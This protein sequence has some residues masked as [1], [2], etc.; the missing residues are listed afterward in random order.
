MGHFN[1]AG[2]TEVEDFW[3]VN[4]HRLLI[5]A[6]EKSGLLEKPRPT[7]ELYGMDADGS[8]QGILI[9]YRAVTQESG[10]H[11]TVG[12][13]TQAGA[14]TMVAH[15]PGD[16]DHVIVAVWPYGSGASG[17][18]KAA[19]MDV[20]TGQTVVVATAPVRNADFTTDLQGNV[21]FATG[22]DN[23][24][25]L[26]TYYRDDAN[27]SWVLLNDAAV[28]K[29]NL[30]PLG[31]GADGRTA[32]LTREDAG[33]GP[34]TLVAYDTTSHT[35]KDVRRDATADPEPVYGAHR[36]LIGVRYVDAKP[37]FVFFNEQGDIEQSFRALEGSFADQAVAP[38]GFTT[39][40]K[41]MLVFVYSDRSPGDYYLFDLGSKKAVHLASHRDWIDPDRMGPQRAVTL[42][43]RDGVVLHGFLT[44]PAGSTGKNLPLVVNPHG[45]PFF[46]ADRW[47]FDGEVQLLASRGYAVLQLNYRGSSGFG[48]QF[49]HS[50]YLQWGR[51]MQDDLTDATKWAIAQGI[52]DPKRI[53]IYGASYGGYAALEGVAK[54]P[55]LYRCAAGYVGVYD[56]PT[57]YHAG[58]V[59]ERKSGEN[60]LKET[61][62]ED[63]LEAISPTHLASRI[64]APVLLAAGKQD[65]RAPPIHTE[66]MRD[67]LQKA[68][69]PVQ[70]TIY[71][72]EGHGFYL[73]ADREAFYNS[74]LAFLDR[75]IGTGAR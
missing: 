49:A 8:N 27:A 10:S 36:E 25:K 26:R 34:D 39:D 42:T 6:G 40:G 54:E 30:T 58:D 19:R 22:A 57:M 16:S 63:G 74:L 33:N 7:G 47:G 64:V 18:E 38:A 60:Y 62:G 11:I 53:C 29:L 71:A 1:L 50:G 14:A 28:S 23:N 20:R 12:K 66:M 35:M 72:G 9:G 5:S 13:R 67:A 43:A 51:A 37:R 3:W 69:K 52:A 24:N 55:N 70:A 44:V 46:V 4:D 73:E 32:Y 68:G 65:E 31:F 15:I 48:R 56:L 45:G 17:Y 41:Q 2:N 21:R 61:L 59:Q 75:N